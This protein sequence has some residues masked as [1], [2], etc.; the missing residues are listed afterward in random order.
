VDLCL[1]S[2]YAFKTCTVITLCL[3]DV[4]NTATT[5]AKFSLLAVYSHETRPNYPT[6]FHQT[7]AC[8]PT[9]NVVQ[10]LSFWFSLDNFK[11][12]FTLMK[13]RSIFRVLRR[14]MNRDTA[15][16]I[17]V[18]YDTPITRIMNRGIS[19]KSDRLL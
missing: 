13:S 19:N 14:T 5:F 17:C 10:L 16:D 12:Y 11:Y 2:Q 4:Q 6:N 1:H 9:L 15:Y 7:R 3:L 18:T 8:G